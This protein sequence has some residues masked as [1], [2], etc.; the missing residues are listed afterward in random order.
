MI[1]TRPIRWTVKC[2]SHCYDLVVT[3]GLRLPLEGKFGLAMSQQDAIRQIGID[4]YVEVELINQRGESE[5][6]AFDIVRDD[7]ADIDEGRLSSTSPLAKA[8]LG[9][10][11]GTTLPYT[12][13]DIRQ[14]RIIAARKSEQ[15]GDAS[16]A[17]RRQA[18]I[19]QAVEKARQTDA[20]IFASSFTSKWGGYD[21]G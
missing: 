10:F 5:R 11:V 21:A 3:I 8:L 13:G 6:M 7:A 2:R 20:E 12:M 15:R 16:A 1:G 9:K 4:I 14:V 19:D 18:I 17:E